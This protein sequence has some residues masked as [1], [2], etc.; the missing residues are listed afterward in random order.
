MH[1][2]RALVEENR[3]E[4]CRGEIE[5]ISNKSCENV[6]RRNTF[7]DCEGT[8]TL[9][10]EVKRALIAENTILD[11]KESIV[12]GVVSTTTGPRE[13][14]RQYDIRRRAGH[15]CA[16]R[17]HNHRPENRCTG[18]ALIKHATLSD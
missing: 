16:G 15:P 4:G 18:R 6:Y 8:L 2:S 11:C 12:I 13:V 3:F 7:V 14:G 10:H 1:D 17:H 5:I 9:R